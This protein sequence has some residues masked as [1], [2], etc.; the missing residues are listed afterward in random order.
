MAGR[1]HRDFGLVG[2]G[3]FCG[4]ESHDLSEEK[5]GDDCPQW[6]PGILGFGRWGWEKCYR[7]FNTENLLGVNILRSLRKGVGAFPL[8]LQLELRSAASSPPQP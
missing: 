1:E 8:V 6:S 3:R 7:C 5:K 4:I 2:E